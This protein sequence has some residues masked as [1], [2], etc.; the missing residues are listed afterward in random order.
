MCAKESEKNTVL[1][2]EKKGKIQLFLSSLVILEEVINSTFTNSE[3]KHTMKIITKIN[4]NQEITLDPESND[5]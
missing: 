2:W 5:N 3:P 1:K 4:K